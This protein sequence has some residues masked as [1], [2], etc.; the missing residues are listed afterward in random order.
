MQINLPAEVEEII[1]TLNNG[2]FEAYIVGGCVRDSLLG[3]TPND[4]DITTNALPEDV[5]NLFKHTVPTGIKHGTITVVMNDNYE[6]TSFRIDGDYGDNRRPDSVKYTSSL[7]D[8]LA[9][10]DFTIN[11][12]AYNHD[13]GLIDYF[14][15]MW[16]LRN[17]MII[18][19]GNAE[20]RYN[21]D[22]LRMIRGIR[23]AAQLNF[24]IALSAFEPIKK[25]KDLIKNISQER[26]RDEL[27]KILLSD[28]PS[29]GLRMLR[30]SGLLEII[31]PELYDCVD[32]DQHNE[33]HNKNVFDH[34]L[35]V[36][37]NTPNDLTIR[38]AALFHDIG[39]PQTFSMGE[40]GNGHFYTHHMR[41][42]DMAEEI[43][44]RLK[45]DNKTISSVCI[46]VKEHMNRFEYL[47]TGNIKRFINR[48]G[49]ENLDLLFELQIAD[50]KGSKPQYDIYDIYDILNLKEECKRIIDEKQ[51]L[52]VKDLA[53]NGHDLMALGYKQGKDIGAILTKLLDLV[54]ENPEL[55][56]K[57]EL[58]GLI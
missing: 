20:D 9:R 43:L 16:G 28:N 45:F 22:S 7:I 56:I 57:D 23:F 33:H 38:L 34:I 30:F 2:G 44:K 49:I 52:T 31:L 48:V 17:K 54:I 1:K 32:F 4:W 46:L 47:R 25:N 36:I 5:Q 8:D 18:C 11:A 58:L 55:N 27:C 35:E 40:N 15:G 12:L 42:M 26:I 19:V 21:E 14:D 41:S 13:K 29:S 10:R 53:I 50:I 24:N 37:D 6:V 39:K 3:R 51:P